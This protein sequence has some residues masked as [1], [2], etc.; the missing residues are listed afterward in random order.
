MLDFPADPPLTVL[1]CGSVMDIY[2][3]RVRHA[4]RLMTLISLVICIFVVVFGISEDYDFLHKYA[5]ATG[6]VQMISE[7]DR[8]EAVLNKWNFGYTNEARGVYMGVLTFAFNGEALYQSTKFLEHA[9]VELFELD[10]TCQKRTQQFDL[11]PRTGPSKT[12]NCHTV[13]LEKSPM[14][15]FIDCESSTVSLYADVGCSAALWQQR[16]PEAACTEV[17]FHLNS[18]AEA[19]CG[20]TGNGRECEFPFTYLG[21]AYTACTT[22]EHDQPWCITETS[23][24]GYSWGNCECGTHNGSH[25]YNMSLSLN[26]LS[27]EYLDAYSLDGHAVDGYVVGVERKELETTVAQMV[28]GDGSKVIK[29]DLEDAD[30]CVDNDAAAVAYAA[31]LGLSISSCSDLTTMCA[32][33]TYGGLV[34][35]SCC[36]TCV[37]SSAFKIDPCISMT[38]VNSLNGVL[39]SYNTS[40]CLGVPNTTNVTLPLAFNSSGGSSYILECLNASQYTKH[41]PSGNYIQ[42]VNSYSQCRGMADWDTIS[43]GCDA[44]LPAEICGKCYDAGVLTF[45]AIVATAAL[46]L[47][48][49]WNAVQRAS[50]M[51]DSRCKKVW[52]LP[53]VL[54]VIGCLLFAYFFWRSMC[55]D[56]SAIMLD[57]LLLHAGWTWATGNLHTNWEAY[58]QLI[59]AGLALVVWL[60]TISIPVPERFQNKSCGADPSVVEPTEN[61]MPDGR[62]HSASQIEASLREGPASL[63]SSQQMKTVTQTKSLF[64]TRSFVREAVAQL[65]PI[66]ADQCTLESTPSTPRSS[67]TPCSVLA[68]HRP[69]FSASCES[70]IAITHC[71]AEAHSLPGH[72]CFSNTKPAWFTGPSPRKNPVE[73]DVG[74]VEE[75]AAF[76]DEHGSRMAM[77]M[78]GSDVFD[79]LTCQMTPPEEFRVMDGT[80]SEMEQL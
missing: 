6:N 37:S 36:T 67:C 55:F 80:R 69:W 66:K 52:S 77:G 39:E 27:T 9:Q 79:E 38:C 65:A 21:Q 35:A 73:D 17:S 58:L 74:D 29:I 32:H 46:Q 14:G 34:T 40:D 16:V 47:P 57:E 43:P 22:V 48:L 33:P 42:C 54:L 30:V 76:V 61:S 2:R 72:Q 59:A 15:L 12:R 28:V 13:L 44:G 71:F 11:V 7:A 68:G 8:L 23:A 78:Q 75:E 64:G 24:N 19:T 50:A 56:E 20:G 1:V 62:C 3:Y 26:C 60:I 53:L 31:Q 41:I 18:T 49:A 51:N 70:T 63:L 25:F 5:W 4:T 45:A 10:T